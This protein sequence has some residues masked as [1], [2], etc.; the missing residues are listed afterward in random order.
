MN[1]K[2]MRRKLAALTPT[3]KIKILEKLRD[4][5][6]SLA[7]AGLRAE[8]RSSEAEVLRKEKANK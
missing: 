7:Q 2:E 6:L 1:K 3:E 4:R 8:L 5:S